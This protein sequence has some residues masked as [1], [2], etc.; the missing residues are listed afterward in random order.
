VA[1]IIIAVFP[2]LLM[3]TTDGNCEF[4]K[5]LKVA[6]SVTAKISSL[7]YQNEKYCTL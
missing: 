7:Q 5:F 2:S 4:W 3:L 6:S 1:L